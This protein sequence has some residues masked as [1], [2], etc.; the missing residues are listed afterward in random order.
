MPNVPVLSIEEL[1][2]PRNLKQLLEEFPKTQDRERIYKELL[3]QE[4]LKI[5]AEQAD[6]M[7]ILKALTEAFP[8][9]KDEIAVKLL[10]LDTFK[11]WAPSTLQL[12]AL[13]DV[14]PE[15]RSGIAARVFNPEVL[16][17]LATTPAAINSLLNLF[18]DLPDYKIQISDFVF[19]DTQ[20]SKIVDNN[21]KNILEL[22]TIFPDKT[23]EM[24]AIVLQS[25]YFKSL[26]EQGNFSFGSFVAGFR[27]HKDHIVSLLS[28]PDIIQSLIKQGSHKVAELCRVFPEYPSFIQQIADEVLKK[29]SSEILIHTATDAQELTAITAFTD[30]VPGFTNRLTNNLI[31]MELIEKLIKNST[32]IEILSSVLPAV[33]KNYIANI[34]LKDATFQL[35]LTPKNSWVKPIKRVEGILHALPE[36]R[37]IIAQKLLDPEQFQAIVTGV[38]DVE[39]LLKALPEFKNKIA[40]QLLA[41][42]NFKINASNYDTVTRLIEL[43][44]DKGPELAIRIRSFVDSKTREHEKKQSASTSGAPLSAEGQERF[45]SS[46]QSRRSSV[47]S[48]QPDLDKKKPRDGEEN[49]SP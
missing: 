4:M 12:Q 1:S 18:P 27:N 23:A 15:H 19:Q 40:Q 16:S 28:N 22:G 2:P 36:N 7:T 14:F 41:V 44:P 20:F 26:S 9:K 37:A 8:N 45:F 48:S 21:V 5:F 47:S 43:F 32:D 49:P 6:S 34:A 46:S 30:N 10:H 33:H 17:I 39:L 25:I 3:T 31:E 35:L 24:A 11:K 13:L 38:G 29:E 42:K